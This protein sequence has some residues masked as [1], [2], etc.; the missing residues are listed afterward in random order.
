MQQDTCLS[1]TKNV[2]S[3]WFEMDRRQEKAEHWGCNMIWCS[4]QK[5]KLMTDIKLN[6]LL[7]YSLLQP[8]IMIVF[9]ILIKVTITNQRSR[10]KTYFMILWCLW[11]RPLNP[12]RVY[13]SCII[14]IFLSAF[15]GSLP[16]SAPE[17]LQGSETSTSSDLWALG[18]ILYYMYTGTCTHAHTHAHQPVHALNMIR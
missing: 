9:H 12:Q 4:N 15:L 10:I 2:W 5:Q 11:W 13:L 16:Y 17:V 6:P 3:G 1:A 8:R 18:C 7:I 14:P